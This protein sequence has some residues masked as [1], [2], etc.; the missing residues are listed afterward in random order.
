MILYRFEYEC[1]DSKF[2]FNTCVFYAGEI[3]EGIQA[4]MSD[5]ERIS[6]MVKI[7]EFNEKKRKH[8]IC[9][10]RGYHYVLKQVDH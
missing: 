5:C 10:V 3:D 2:G 1:Y 6:N 7:T 9:E 8:F 4:F